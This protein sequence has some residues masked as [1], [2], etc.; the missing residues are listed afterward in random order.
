M[1]PLRNC[2]CPLT[3]CRLVL[4]QL[5]SCRKTDEKLEALPYLL[6]PSF[7]LKYVPA[8]SAFAVVA[9]L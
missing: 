5:V 6:V 4:W 1:V 7:I 8:N 3:T 9:S 2:R